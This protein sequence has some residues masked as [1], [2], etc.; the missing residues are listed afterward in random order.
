MIY[1][2]SRFLAIELLLVTTGC[3]PM[4]QFFCGPDQSPWVDK[5]YATPQVAVAT[6]LEAIRRDDSRQIYQSLSENFKVRE[7]LPGALE[8]ELAWR[9]LRKRYGYLHMLGTADVRRASQ[10]SQ[11]LVSFELLLA[12]HHIRIDLRRQD[13][14]S[15][16]Y[17]VDG[18]I[19][20][21]REGRYVDSLDPFLQIL[22]PTDDGT[23]L[24]FSLTE[25]EVEGLQPSELQRV[26]LA[27]EWKIDSISELGAD[28]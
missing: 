3:C 5:S 8:F 22:P 20:P 6:F 11:Q 27:R 15:L 4:A 24:V 13:Y 23:T 7:G 21:L 28:L 25:L 19:E 9:Q 12:G 10:I 18:L 1:R 2:Q 16:S 26:E 14:L 17:E